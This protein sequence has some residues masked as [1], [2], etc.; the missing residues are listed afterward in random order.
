LHGVLTHQ[1]EGA[2]EMHDSRNLDLFSHV[3]NQRR[4]INIVSTARRAAACLAVISAAASQACGDADS[5]RLLDTTLALSATSIGLQDEHLEP[6]STDVANTSPTKPALVTRD[7]PGFKGVLGIDSD[8]V[9]A[10]SSKHYN[11]DGRWTNLRSVIYLD[12][13]LDGVLDSV[14]KRTVGPLLPANGTFASPGSVA[15]GTQFGELLHGNT[16]K[17]T[18][19]ARASS[20]ETLQSEQPLYLKLSDTVAVVPVV[21]INWRKRDDPNYL[22]YWAIGKNV[23]DFIPFHQP[24]WIPPQL[25]LTQIETPNDPSGN[26]VPPD[27]GGMIPPD[28]LWTQCGVQFQVI[29]SFDFELPSDWEPLCS[30]FVQRSFPHPAPL[31]RAALGPVSG[32]FVVDGLQPVYL[33]YGNLH[34]CSDEIQGGFKGATSVDHATVSYQGAGP[35]TAHELGHT[36]LG[37]A[38]ATTCNVPDENGNVTLW[39]LCAPIQGNLMRENPDVYDTAIAPSQCK[40]AYDGA[41]PYSH[42]YDAFNWKLGRSRRPETTLIEELPAVYDGVTLPVGG[43]VLAEPMCCSV[44]DSFFVTNRDQCELDGGTLADPVECEKCCVSGGSATLR[45]ADQCFPEEESLQEKSDCDRIC[46]STNPSTYVERYE[47]TQAG[48]VEV[49]CVP[50]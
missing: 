12:T 25:S 23:L 17:A 21:L 36:L 7:N 39:P 38:H 35:I 40:S 26:I 34:P 37:P 45:F 16:Y 27:Y 49:A 2:T 3:S 22:D 18:V 8:N 47:C 41:L 15:W 30:P 29:L 46:C 44:G 42:R 11:A 33:S 50:H 4:L 19:F 9:T 32:P 43:H 20:G 48:G 14:E 10:A 1:Q 28:D 13:Y 5:D 6:S 24:D 31:V